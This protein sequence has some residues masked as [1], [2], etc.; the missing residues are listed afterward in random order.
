MKY[1]DIIPNTVFTITE[2]K[3]S[4]SEYLHKYKWF[5]LFNGI[6][7]ICDSEEEAYIEAM[8]HQ[9]LIKNQIN[10][11][12]IIDN[13]KKDIIDSIKYKLELSYDQYNKF[14][15]KN[16]KYCEYIDDENDI[17]I[18]YNGIIYNYEQFIIIISKKIA[19]I[20]TIINK[21]N[22]ESLIKQVSNIFYNISLIRI[23]KYNNFIYI[24]FNTNKKLYE[25]YIGSIIKNASDNCC[26]HMDVT[27]EYEFSTDNIK[28]N[29]EK[30]FTE[31]NKQL[32]EY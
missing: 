26:G 7:N 13:T 22:I 17:L 28:H 12:L 23:I 1:K 24:L 31:L 8:Y 15:D 5:S 14:F 32:S 9:Q 19:K 27:F 29:K 11:D 21:I 16:K 4:E 3:N 10:L 25:K 20:L 30:F 18:L 6:S 2:I